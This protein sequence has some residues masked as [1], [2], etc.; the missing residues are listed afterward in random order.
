MSF[1]KQNREGKIFNCYQ[2]SRSE[3]SQTNL[4]CLSIA[5]VMYIVEFLVTEFVL[6]GDTEVPK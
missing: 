6:L 5:S 4:I 1:L 3:A 2:N